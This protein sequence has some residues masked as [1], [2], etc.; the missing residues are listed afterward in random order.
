MPVKNPPNGPRHKITTDDCAVICYAVLDESVGYVA[1]HG[2][3]FVDGKEIGKVPGSAI[4]QNKS[5]LFTLYYC[6]SLWN[7]IGVA[8][9]YKSVDA[10]VETNSAIRA[11]IGTWIR[12]GEN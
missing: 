2:L 3:F 6:D 10:G 7:P 5:R 9:N 1:G 4:C 11:K 8:T 12:F